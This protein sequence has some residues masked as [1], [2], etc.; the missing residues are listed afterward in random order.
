MVITIGRQFGSGGSEIGRRV[1]EQLGIPYYDKNIIDHVADKLGLSPQYVSRVEEKPT[2]SF[3]YSMAM[4]TYGTATDSGILPTEL[5]ISSAQSEFILERAEE[6]DCVIVGRC[7]DYILRNRSDVLNV[8]IYGEMQDRIKT[9]MERYHLGEREAVRIITQTDKRRA[10]YYNTN[11]Q[12]RW[13]ARESYH[14]LVDSSRFGIDGAVKL[15][16]AA[17]AAEK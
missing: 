8:F 3:L 4:Y 5:Q 6:G 9:V 14:L 13:S 10:M 7:A 1:A 2:G 12:R 15:I 17:Y 16:C 11:T